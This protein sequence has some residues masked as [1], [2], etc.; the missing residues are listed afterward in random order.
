M[1]TNVGTIEYT[2][3]AKTGALLTAGKQADDAFD[4]IE[5]G[6][7]KADSNLKTLNKQVKKT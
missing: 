6:A 7:K 5:R 1:T 4:R 3:D 2:V